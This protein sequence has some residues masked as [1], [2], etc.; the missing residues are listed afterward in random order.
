MC[1]LFL[2]FHFAYVCLIFRIDNANIQQNEVMQL[3]NEDISDFAIDWIHN[4]IFTARNIAN[5]PLNQI[6]VANVNEVNLAYILFDAKQ[7][8]LNSIAIELNDKFTFFTQKS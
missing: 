4:L 7:K 1:N 8:S 5:I 2:R 3:L 6:R